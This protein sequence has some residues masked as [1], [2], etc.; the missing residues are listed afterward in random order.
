MKTFALTINID[1]EDIR[2]IF[3]NADSIESC[4]KIYEYN[5]G[6]DKDPAPGDWDYDVVEYHEL[7]LINIESIIS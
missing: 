2:T 5:Q 3:I 7:P 4:Q 1:N 6:N